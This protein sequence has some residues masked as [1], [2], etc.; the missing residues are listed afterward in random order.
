MMRLQE[1]DSP[2]HF[3]QLLS[4]R[5]SFPKPELQVSSIRNYT[6]PFLFPPFLW[7]QEHNLIFNFFP[8]EAWVCHV[9]KDFLLNCYVRTSQKGWMRWL[10]GLNAHLVTAG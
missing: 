4:D 6:V 7:L 3:T 9:I 1:N 2:D 5:S 8:L 10:S